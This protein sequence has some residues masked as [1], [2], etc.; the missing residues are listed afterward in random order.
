MPTKRQEIKCH[1]TCSLRFLEW[2]K[3]ALTFQWAVGNCSKIIRKRFISV[4]KSPVVI[5]AEGPWI[6]QCERFLLNKLLDLDS[7]DFGRWEGVEHRTGIVTPQKLF[8]FSN[9]TMLQL[10]HFLSEWMKHPATSLNTC[11]FSFHIGQ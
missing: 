6:L 3:N 8:S 2:K 9:T 7:I 11:C 1:I 10:F 4:R 5:D